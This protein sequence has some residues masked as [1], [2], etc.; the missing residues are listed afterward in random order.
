MPQ[1][2]SF[3]WFWLQA[4][5]LMP[6]GPSTTISSIQS[7]AR[8]NISFKFLA[9]SDMKGSTESSERAS[10]RAL[11]FASLWPGVWRPIRGHSN[12]AI[13]ALV[14]ADATWVGCLIWIQCPLYGKVRDAEF[15]ILLQ[16]NFFISRRIRVMFPFIMG[17]QRLLNE[18]FM[19]I[20]ILRS[21]SRQWKLDI[22]MKWH[23]LDL[24][25]ALSSKILA[26][27][28]RV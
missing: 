23:H 27:Q 3:D 26:K 16:D 17:G 18:S 22:E 20:P 13:Q 5:T 4:S 6:W 2:E 8:R 11:C 1:E 12:E 10:W 14:S 28:F 25:I 9:G 19:S 7:F 15:R 24:R 21:I